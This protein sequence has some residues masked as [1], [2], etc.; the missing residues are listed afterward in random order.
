[1]SWKK[2]SLALGLALLTAPAFSKISTSMNAQNT[3]YDISVDD[4]KIEKVLIEGQS[5]DQL[6]LVGVDQMSAIKYEQG[7]PLIPVLRFYAFADKA[8]DI[9]VSAF[10]SKTNTY[11]TVQNIMPVLPSLVKTAGSHYQASDLVVS[12]EAL[13]TELFQVEDAGIVR[14]QQ[15]FLITLYPVNLEANKA[16]VKNHFQ[17]KIKTPASQI[18]PM[19]AQDGLLFIV[20]SKFKNSASLAKYKELKKS[21]GFNIYT[22]EVTQNDPELIRASV[23]DLYQKNPNIKFA[24]IVGDA[25]DVAGKDSTIITGST[26]H[27]YAALGEDYENDINAPELSIGRVTAKDVKEMDGIFNKMT[28]YLND[29][30]ST[31]SLMD[32]VSFLA[33]DDRYE[34]AEGSHNY[35]I[36]T[37]TKKAKYKGVFPKNNQV[38]GDKLYAI[39]NKA[40]NDDVMKAISKGRTIINYSG[41]GAT[42]YWDAPEVTQEN[43]RSLKSKTLPFVISN[44]CITG[45]FRE[46]ESFAETWI[47]H[48]F[49]AIM[50]FGSMDSSYWDEDDILERRMFDGIFTL[51]KQNFG[52]ITDFGLSETWR[53]YGGEEKS[54]YYRETYHMFGDPSLKLKISPFQVLF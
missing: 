16:M 7:A 38:G 29:A 44:A 24:L 13:T 50:F 32:Y 3:V 48:E 15:R 21:L 35:V 5:F 17:V 14:G 37:Y 30:Y 11:K 52:E 45:D 2:I 1:M 33:T 20:G 40:K 39:T 26:D 25:E 34:V 49:G 9:E 54:K 31:E 23:K 10:A 36:D 4:L 8:S 28:R 41:H 43:V 42:T 19:E 6:K 18:I 27:Y 51:N 46:D 12:K 47:R 53:H 22:L